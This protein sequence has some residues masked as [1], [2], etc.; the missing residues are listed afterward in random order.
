MMLDIHVQ[1]PQALLL[2]IEP[3]IMR[4]GDSIAMFVDVSTSDW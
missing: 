4:H 2:L 3:S 1:A